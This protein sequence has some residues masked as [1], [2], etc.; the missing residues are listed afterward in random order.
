MMCVPLP[1]L[2]TLQQWLVLRAKPSTITTDGAGKPHSCSLF[3]A[4][5]VRLLL[6]GKQTL[7]PECKRHPGRKA[8]KVDAILAA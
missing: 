4:F 6:A 3:L 2:L 1:W 5:Q 8:C 7:S